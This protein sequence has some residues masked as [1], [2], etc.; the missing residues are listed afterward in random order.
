VTDGVV[1]LW[2]LVDSPEQRRALQVAARDVAGVRAV[3]DHLGE[4]APYLRGI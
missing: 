3:E 2:G 4:V 1:H